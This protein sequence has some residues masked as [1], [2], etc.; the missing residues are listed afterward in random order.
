M[1]REGSPRTTRNMARN[2]GTLS[3]P[4]TLLVIAFRSNCMPVTMKKMGMNTPKPTAS[5]RGKGGRTRD[6]A[7]G[8]EQQRRD[9]AVGG[10]AQEQRDQDDGADLAARAGGGH[11]RAE[12]SLGIPL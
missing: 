9:A 8:H 11:Q 5:W 2:R 1:R 10:L 6:Q 3:M 7:E 4:E 12:S